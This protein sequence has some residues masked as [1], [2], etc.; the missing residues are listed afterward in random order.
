MDYE[1]EAFAV[2]DITEMDINGLQQ[3]VD[4]GYLTYEQIMMLYL[5]RINAYADMYKCIIY[6]SDTAIEEARECDR[7]YGMYGRTSDVFGLPVIVKDNID[8]CGMPTTNGESYLSDN[9]ATEDA[10]VVA[11]LKAAGAIIVAKSN[12]DTYA[13]HSQYSISDFGRVNNAFDLNKTSYGSSGG[14]AVSAAAS[15]APICIGTDTNASVRVPSAANGVV[16]IRPTKGLLSTDGITPLIE[17]R[18]TAGPIAKTVEDAAVILSAMTGYDTD[19]TEVLDGA[20]LSGVRIGIVDNLA[21]RSTPVVSELFNDAVAVL[22]NEGAEVIHITITLGSSYNCNVAAYNRVFTA[23]LDK[24]DVDVVIYPTLYGE[25]LTHSAALSGSNSNGWYISPSAGVPAITV[26]MGVD[27]SGVP[28][29]IE[30]VGRSYAEET[31]ISAA[32]V[33]EQASGISVKT[34]LAPNL[35]TSVPE[36]EE[37]IELR[38]SGV[39]EEAASGESADGQYDRVLE[40]YNSAVSYLSTSYYDDDDAAYVAGRLIEDY[41]SEILSYRASCWQFMKIGNEDILVC[42]KMF[43]ALKGIMN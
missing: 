27:S 14:S 12:M 10:E 26:P 30:F 32:Y 7:I 24:Y 36:I 15:L 13:E 9:I 33:Y 29:G 11:Q 39:I 38:N 8:V 37:L 25:A 23:A 35:Y 18:D 40:A 31:I 1:P 20:S 28:S 43:S 3:A 22:Q 2:V 4:D 21:G 41:E 16:G 42:M 19:Y 17:D 5:D 34:S 6:V